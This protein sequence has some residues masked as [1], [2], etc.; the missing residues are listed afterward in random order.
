MFFHF[1]FTLCLSRRM[2]VAATP[3]ICNF[4]V[5]FDFWFACVCTDEEGETVFATFD[6][7]LFLLFSLF[8]HF[9]WLFPF[10]TVW[11]ECVTCA[12]HLKWS[13]VESIFTIKND[14]IRWYFC[15]DCL[16][17]SLLSTFEMIL[18]F[19]LIETGI[20]RKKNI[21][22]V[23]MPNSVVFRGLFFHLFFRTFQAKPQNIRASLLHPAYV[24]SR[25]WF[26]FALV[27]FFLFLLRTYFLHLN[28]F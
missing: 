22:L 23:F 4:H 20:F 2:N 7:L 9:L 17:H 24:L 3:T 8:L 15:N 5:D 6:T 18:R 1:S 28:H 13:F 26:V 19:R 10:F 27:F 11:C 14:K 21:E 12:L 16:F 25:F